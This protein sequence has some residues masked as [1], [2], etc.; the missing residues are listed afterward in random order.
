MTSTARPIT[1]VIVGAGHRS[2]CYGRYGVKNPDELKIVA[3]AE[4]NEFRRKQTAE[5]FGIPSDLCFETAEELASRPRFADAAINGTMDR[6]HIPTSLP[7]L[8]KGYDLL[9]EKPIAP[10]AAEVLSL[11]DAARKYGSMVMI[12]HV[13]RYAPFYAAVRQR[14]ADGEIG[15]LLSVQTQENVSYHHMAVGF[16]RGKWN[17]EGES[18]SMLMAKCCHDMDLITWMMSGI[19][20]KSVSSFGSR[21]Y[22]R[23]EKAP[24]GSGTRCLLD[25]AIE[26]DCPYSAKK[27]YIEQGL[28][29]FYAWQPVE[30]LNLNTEGKIASL[31]EDNPFGRCVWACDNDVVDHQAVIVEFADGCTA[32]HNMVGGVSRP[33][34]SIHLIGTEGEIQGV[35]DEGSFV[36]RH[37]DARAGHEYAEERVEINVKGDGHGGGDHRL[38]A[39]FVRVLRGEPA[40]ISTTSLEDSVYGH[41]IG[42]AADVSRVEHRVIPIQG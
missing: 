29:G 17:R 21:M 25:C 33:C 37:P 39:D 7:L 19:A 3:V 14:V 8:E 38:V 18:N 4:P 30:H 34:R 9:L 13:L 36:V 11:R 35:M 20:P 32:T 6:D 16:V 41:L 31:R 28:W 5:E 22:F 2:V 1:A 26:A 10:S 12:C 40:S 27:H 42:F 15:Q 24:A 23:P